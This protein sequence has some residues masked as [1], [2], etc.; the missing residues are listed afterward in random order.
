MNEIKT[1]KNNNIIIF[2]ISIILIIVSGIVALLFF[3]NDSNKNNPLLTQ[4][5][6]LWYANIVEVYNEELDEYETRGFSQYFGNEIVESNELIFNYDNTFKCKFLNDSGKYEIANNKIYMLSDIKEVSYK[7]E[8]NDEELV[9]ILEDNTRIYLEKDK[10]EKVPADSN[11]EIKRAEQI[12]YNQFG[13]SS[14]EYIDGIKYTYTY[15]Y[16]YVGEYM[17]KKNQIYYV[18]DLKRQSNDSN[19]LSSVG[20]YAVSIEEQDYYFVNNTDFTETGIIEI[21]P[22]VIN[23]ESSKDLY[24]TLIELYG[25]E[26]DPN[27][28]EKLF[29]GLIDGQLFIVDPLNNYNGDSAGIDNIK[30]IEKIVKNNSCDIFDLYYL[31]HDNELYKIPNG[32]VTISSTNEKIVKVASNVKNFYV[33]YG[34]QYILNV[35]KLDGTIDKEIIIDWSNFE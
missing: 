6:G 31:T 30:K 4:L 7:A 28:E 14:E 8:L 5:V 25:Y 29:I 26:C 10:K 1:Q 27:N 16:I 32:D 35:E 17:D 21:E 3:K 15:N 23:E 19:N 11:E 12:L 13:D 2:G 33:T 9:L 18:F 24:D 20:Y 34:E 22:K